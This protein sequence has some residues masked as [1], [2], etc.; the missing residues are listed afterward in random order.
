MA[1]DLNQIVKSKQFQETLGSLSQSLGVDGDE[2]QKTINDPQFAS[3]IGDMANSLDLDSILSTAGNI[4]GADS[5]QLKMVKQGIS[6]M[7]NNLS[8]ILN[9]PKDVE[10][11]VTI[12]QAQAYSGYRK[13]LQV[14]RL[15]FDS[16]KNAMV[17]EKSKLV[18]NV[19]AGINSGYVMNVEGYGDQYYSSDKQL[20]NS[21]LLVTINVESHED[22]KLLDKDLVYKLNVQLSEFSEDKT[23]EVTFLDGES[24]KLFKPKTFKPKGRLV[25]IIKGLGFPPDPESDSEDFGDLIILFNLKWKGEGKMVEAMKSIESLEEVAAPQADSDSN[26]YEIKEY[27]PKDL[28]F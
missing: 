5:D 16:A 15:V 26:T 25:G 3:S 18:I 9:K 20:K 19:P 22:F 23:Y 24:I 12:T 1:L 21:N 4:I 14:K 6:G 2:I 17:Q 11:S 27:T 28:W 13:H 10:V 7:Q 8:D